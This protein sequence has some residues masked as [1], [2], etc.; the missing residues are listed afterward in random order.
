LVLAVTRREEPV[1]GR[2]ALLPEAE[3][4][5]RGLLLP[6]VGP[7]REVTEPGDDRLAGAGGLPLRPGGRGHEGADLRA[8]PGHDV[9]LALVEE[10]DEPVPLGLEG[11]GHQ[12][13]FW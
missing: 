7:R 3:D 12:E 1:Q 6:L 5:V 10:R 8:Q 9:A 2:V 11:A 4:A 13:S